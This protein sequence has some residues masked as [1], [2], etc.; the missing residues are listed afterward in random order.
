MLVLLALNIRVLLR[1]FCSTEECN[2]PVETELGKYYAVR[3]DPFWR[4]FT[5]G[6]PNSGRNANIYFLPILAY[7]SG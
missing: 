1:S 5:S 7:E 6:Y 3:D 2:K 4:L